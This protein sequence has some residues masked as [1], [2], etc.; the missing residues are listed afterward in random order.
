MVNFHDPIVLLKEFG[1]CVPRPFS[2][3]VTDSPSRIIE[4]FLGSCEWYLYVGL[5]L[6]GI[7]PFR[8]VI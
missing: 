7:L 3:K 2:P 5:P 8:F 4:V 6:I 1:A